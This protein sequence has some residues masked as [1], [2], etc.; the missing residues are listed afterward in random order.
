LDIIISRISTFNTAKYLLHFDVH[1]KNLFLNII[2][3]FRTIDL[4]TMT[5]KGRVP[6]VDGISCVHTVWV[7][8]SVIMTSLYSQLTLNVNLNLIR[9][10]LSFS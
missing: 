10:D 2:K 6:F 8:K 9:R 7:I 5:V 3:T 1:F 4:L